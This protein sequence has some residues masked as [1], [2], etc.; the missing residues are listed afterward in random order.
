MVRA[1]PS[2]LTPKEVDVHLNALKDAPL[3]RGLGGGRIRQLV[4]RPDTLF[5]RL[6][7]GSEI[8]WQPADKPTHVFV[9]ARG[10]LRRRGEET[11]AYQAGEVIAE[12]QPTIF[13]A[14]AEKDKRGQVIQPCV[15]VAFN[16]DEWRRLMDEAPKVREWAAQLKA[17]PLFAEVAD[18]DWLRLLNSD[19]VQF[20]RF[21]SGEVIC[22]EGARETTAY[23]LLRGIVEVYETR[24][25]RE[26]RIAELT[27]G[28]IFGEIGALSLCVRTASCRAKTEGVALEVDGRPLR[29][30]LKRAPK[31]AQVV[32]RHYLERGLLDLL[33]DHKLKDILSPETV[34]RI[35]ADNLAELRSY[36]PQEVIL[37]EGVADADLAERLAHKEKV[38]YE[39][40][41]GLYIVLFGHVAITKG[42]RIF[43]YL[44]P[45]GYFGE[46]SLLTGNPPMAT[47]VAV[48]DADCAFIAKEHFHALMA[49]DAF[50]REAMLRVARQRLGGQVAEVPPL[51]QRLM[52]R[53]RQLF[54]PFQ[55]DENI[56]TFAPSEVIVREGE[57]GDT[58]YILLSGWAQVLHYSPRLRRDITIALLGP[59]QF[60]GEMALLREASRT[61]TVRVAAS[62]ASEAKVLCVPRD[63]FLSVLAHHPDVR[64]DLERLMDERTNALQRRMATE[65]VVYEQLAGEEIF[66]GDAVMMID[67][68]RCI[69]CGNCV[70]ACAMVHDDGIS[71]INWQGP[72]LTDGKPI[73]LFPFVCRHCVDPVCM[74]DCP[75]TAIVRGEETG[76]IYI[77]PDLCI[78]CRACLRNC[79]YGAI[80]MQPVP[81]SSEATPQTSRPTEGL[82]AWLRRLFGQPSPT[83]SPA[84]PSTAPALLAVKCDLC[85]GMAFQ[86]CVYHCPVGAVWRI[87]PR[88]FFG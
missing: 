35:A 45:G 31:V 19:G 58:F 64:A 29:R 70:T 30:F 71:R 54:A 13:I 40:V 61:A 50:F 5:F 12:G 32:Y 36:E 6:D 42:N 8:V 76:E 68:T 79:P 80:Q 55:T 14:E 72:T 16:A 7:D 39:R 23:F 49:E 81:Q 34:H 27:D 87:E 53:M 3:L 1:S 63:R 85:R 25:G 37:Q 33:R 4:E 51:E 15:L 11:V 74:R 67:L 66:V 57:V 82:T 22:R 17:M 10:N 73:A 77:R 83:P 60:F 47:V 65:D 59:G 43:A 38:K 28:A 78:G 52:E 9:L 21:A 2:V 56:R 41:E 18:G 86:A 69:R 20:R 88:K 75:T 46:L 62:S 26:E 24:Q 84:A 44:G 48:E